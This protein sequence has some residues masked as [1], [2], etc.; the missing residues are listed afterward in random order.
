MLDRIHEFG[1]LLRKN[2][3]RVSISEVVDAVRAA[4]LVGFERA[5]DLRAAL[6]ASLVKKPGD[7]A[8]FDE[9]FSL[10]FLRGADLARNLEGSSLAQILAGLGLDEDDIE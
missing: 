10:F 6:S 8:V 7:Q 3:V 2:Q 5:D 4:E 1:A 9:L